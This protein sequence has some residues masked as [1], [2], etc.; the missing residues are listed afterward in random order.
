MLTKIFVRRR[1]SS[2]CVHVQYRKCTCVPY[3]PLGYVRPDSLYMILPSLEHLS[4][5]TDGSI[6]PRIQ[7]SNLLISDIRY[8]NVAIVQI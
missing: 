5:K 3:N 7:L 2:M 1:M 6:L 4:K 8:M